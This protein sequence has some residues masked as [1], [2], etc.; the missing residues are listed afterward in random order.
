MVDESGESMHNILTACK[1]TR[2][3]FVTLDLYDVLRYGC[4]VLY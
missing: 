2:L 1:P 3:G 4:L